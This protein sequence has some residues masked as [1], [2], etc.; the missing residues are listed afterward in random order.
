MAKFD[1]S[2]VERVRSIPYNGDLYH[3]YHINGVLTSIT[4]RYDNMSREATAIDWNDLP[5]E[6]QHRID[7]E[8]NF[9]DKK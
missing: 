8:I 5:V 2:K 3:V 4:V 6:L 1:S 7:D 9:G